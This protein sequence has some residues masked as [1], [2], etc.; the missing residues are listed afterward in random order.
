MGRAVPGKSH[1]L[2]NRDLFD[3]FA[4][5]LAA[6]KWDVALLQEV[7][8]RWDE[9]LAAATKSNRFR[10]LTSRMWISP[11]CSPIARIRP[12]LPSSWEGGS[13]LILVRKERPGSAIAQKENRNLTWAPERRVLSM[14][15]LADGFCV[16][17][18]HASTGRERG[19]RDV[20]KAAEIA[21]HWAGDSPLILGGDF[22]IRPRKSEAVFTEL[23]EYYGF[24]EPTEPASIDHLLLRGGS[25]VEPTAS[26][27]PERRD[28]P[29][30]E[31][32]LLV[33]LSDH[34]PVVSQIS[35]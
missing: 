32:D 13:N 8:P 12:H 19:E 11:F 3:E 35:V 5:L 18:L 33:R 6:A 2:L 17:N 1:V 34:S 20:L 30:P 4:A 21:V 7:P 28:V 16:A 24:S 10:A 15:R 9:R 27:K 31:S 25:V 22:N 26:W 23:R 14:V 29:D